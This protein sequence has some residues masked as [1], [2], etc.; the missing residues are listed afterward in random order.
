MNNPFTG[1]TNG[2]KNQM[3][4]QQYLYDAIASQKFISNNYNTFANECVNTN[5]KQDFLNILKE[6]HHIQ[7]ELFQEAQS[8]GW[9]QVPAAEQQK[10][11]SAKQKFS[12]MNA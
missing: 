7:A 9:Y 2:A 12:D 5:L 8:R 11:D 6:E 4:D 3:N 10:I 1:A